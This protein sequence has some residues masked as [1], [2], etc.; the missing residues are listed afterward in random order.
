MQS[1][2]LHDGDGHAAA[3][4]ETRRIL[5]EMERLEMRA[6]LLLAEHRHVM[7]TISDLQIQL[8]AAVP[9]GRI[10]RPRGK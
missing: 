4:S 10:A 6:R 1:A 3:M 8:E 7:A 5:D 2:N 9:T